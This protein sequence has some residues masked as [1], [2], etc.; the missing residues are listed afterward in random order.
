MGE[1]AKYPRMSKG[2]RRT[3]AVTYVSL[4]SETGDFAGDIQIGKGKREFARPLT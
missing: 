3:S 2:Y 4:E 1:S